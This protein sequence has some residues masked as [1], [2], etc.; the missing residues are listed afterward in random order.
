MKVIKRHG[1]QIF[2]SFDSS[3][4]RD[5]SFSLKCTRKSWID[6]FFTVEESVI[7][8]SLF[9]RRDENYRKIS[10][11]SW[12]LEITRQ[13]E[14]HITAI[15]S[16]FVV[17]RIFCMRLFPNGVSVVDFTWPGNMIRR[18]DDENIKYTLPSPGTLIDRPT[19]SRSYISPRNF[20]TGIYSRV[21]Q[22]ILYTI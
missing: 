18:K 9:R 1:L 6:F 5:C 10:D 19:R 14:I 17:R 21:C 20:R 7:D 16:D 11:K 8:S 15:F 12:F 2:A 4:S 22:I 3:A 13:C